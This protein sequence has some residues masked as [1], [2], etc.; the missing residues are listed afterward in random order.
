VGIVDLRHRSD[1]GHAG[2]EGG[3]ELD[4]ADIWRPS[5]IALATCFNPPEFSTRAVS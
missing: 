2:V 3:A 4:R 5:W 1:R